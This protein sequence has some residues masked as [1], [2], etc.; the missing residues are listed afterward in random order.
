MLMLFNLAKPT[1]ALITMCANKVENSTYFNR[2]VPC[3]AHQFFRCNL[4]TVI[5]KYD[6]K[7]LSVTVMSILS[8]VLH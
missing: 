3:T 1:L 6:K 7:V 4:I 8:H 5:T 2:M